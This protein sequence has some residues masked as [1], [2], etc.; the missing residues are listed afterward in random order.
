MPRSVKG[1]QGHTPFSRVLRASQYAPPFTTR[2]GSRHDNRP[3][4]DGKPLRPS[5]RSLP[6]PGAENGVWHIVGAQSM[7]LKGRDRVN[8]GGRGK[9]ASK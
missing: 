1:V 9:H 6:E 8:L 7:V 4:V 2:V 3:S 5:T